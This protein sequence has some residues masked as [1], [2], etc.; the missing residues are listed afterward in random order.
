MKKILFAIL[1]IALSVSCSK[2]SNFDT[3]DTAALAAE[4]AAK[5][6][7]FNGST[8]SYDA[9]RAKVMTPSR[10]MSSP[11]MKGETSTKKYM[12]K[13]LISRVLLPS[14]LIKKGSMRNIP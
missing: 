4:Q 11:A 13:P 12:Y 10:A 8:I 6:K 1:P 9:L 5:A 7:T 3:P 14:L 2:V